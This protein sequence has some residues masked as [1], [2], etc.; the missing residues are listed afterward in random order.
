MIEG[1]YSRLLP[2]GLERTKGFILLDVSAMPPPAYQKADNRPSSQSLPFRVRQDAAIPA[3]RKQSESGRCEL[4]CDAYR[5]EMIDAVR[6]DLDETLFDRTTSFSALLSDQSK[7]FSGSLESV[8][9]DEWRD[10]FLAIDRRGHVH[11]TL[12]YRAV[13]RAFGGGAT[14][15]RLFAD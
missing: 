1:S 11:K 13:L 12:V 7:R 9:L 6:F 14:A 15:D 10:R 8:S 5:R 3:G 2:Q 4:P